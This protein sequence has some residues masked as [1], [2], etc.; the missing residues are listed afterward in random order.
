MGDLITK[1]RQKVCRHRDLEMVAICHNNEM[2]RGLYGQS[3]TIVCKCKKCGKNPYCLDVDGI[4]L[5]LRQREEI[6]HGLR[7]AE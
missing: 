4:W 3:T 5:E 7:D 6:N 1:I 2:N